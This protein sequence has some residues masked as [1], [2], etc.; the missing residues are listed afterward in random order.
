VKSGRNLITVRV[1]DHYLGGG[2][3]GSAENMFIVTNQKGENKISLAGDWHYNVAV[4][5]QQMPIKPGQYGHQVATMLFN[6]MVNPVIPYGIK[7]VIWYQGESNVARYNQYRRLSEVMITDWRQQWDQGDFPFLYVQLA[8]LNWNDWPLLREAQLQTREVP[9]TA[10][11]V[12]VDLGDEVDIHPKNKQ[13]VGHRLALAARAIAYDED[14]IYSGPIYKSMKIIDN[15]IQLNFDHIGSGLVSH[16]GDDLKGFTIAGEDKK[17]V[18]A[19]ARIDGDTVVVSHPDI[20]NPIAVRYAW[21]TFPDND[22]YNKEGLP[23]SPF[24]TDNFK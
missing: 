13:D 14:I 23:A 7:G 8:G 10:M 24:R 4:A 9:N 15:S 12:A 18:P 22:L 21:N 5:L 19:Q 2:F 1:F 3:G 6:G 20:Q 16:G 11:V 17:F